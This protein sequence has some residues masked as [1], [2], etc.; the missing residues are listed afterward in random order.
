MAIVTTHDQNYPVSAG[1]LQR[2]HGKVHV[3]YAFIR[4]IFLFIIAT[5]INY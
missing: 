2:P 4:A 1:N 3:G 5:L